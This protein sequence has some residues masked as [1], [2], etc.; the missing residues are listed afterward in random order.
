[1]DAHHYDKIADKL[2][3]FRSKLPQHSHLDNETAQKYVRELKE[4]IAQM[5]FDIEQLAD[6][7][8]KGWIR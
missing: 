2:M 7:D 3:Q 5:L 8:D 6:W 4:Q 1:M